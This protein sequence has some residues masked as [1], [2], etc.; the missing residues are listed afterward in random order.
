LPDSVALVGDER[1]RHQHD[2]TGTTSPDRVWT[3]DEVSIRET[4]RGI[5][6]TFSWQA[7]I[8]RREQ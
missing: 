6:L 7:P 8:G 4:E 5:R 1:R 3:G 2:R